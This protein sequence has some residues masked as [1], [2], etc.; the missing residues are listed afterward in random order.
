M[1]KKAVRGW[2]RFMLIFIAV[3]IP[4]AIFRIWTGAAEPIPL[5][6]LLSLLPPFFLATFAGAC[7]YTATERFR[8]RAGGYYL[9]WAL[10][11][12][13][14]GVVIVLIGIAAFT[15]GEEAPFEIAVAAIVSSAVVVLASCTAVA[16]G[17]EAK[18]M[19]WATLRIEHREG[20]SE[21]S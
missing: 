3:T 18:R 12:A 8:A 9:S 4:F 21:T 10:S 13:I 1:I 16:Y 11:G 14:T 5:R 7:T 17:W 20:A 15:L 2:I 6:D 19:G